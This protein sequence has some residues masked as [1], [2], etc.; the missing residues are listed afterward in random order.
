MFNNKLHIFWIFLQHLLEGRLEL[1]A[2]GSLIVSKDDNG[3]GSLRRSSKRKPRHIDL[4]TALR[5]K[6]LARHKQETENQKD[7]HPLHV[8]KAPLLE[9]LPQPLEIV[10]ITS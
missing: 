9:F 4:M 2:V 1:P 3:D 6:G 8:S 5:R 10:L 7:H